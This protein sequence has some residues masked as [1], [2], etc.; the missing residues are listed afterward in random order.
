MKN[1]AVDISQPNEVLKAAPKAAL[2]TD[3][4]SD[5]DIA[6]K[7]AAPSCTELRMQLE[8][9]MLRERVQENCQMRCVHS[10]AMLADC[11]TK[12]MDSTTLRN[13]LAGGHY[14]LFDYST[15]RAGHRQSLKWRKERETSRIVCR[16]SNLNSSST[17]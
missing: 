8:W 16:Q 1:P 3:C 2:V 6:T 10:K 9:L 12:V 4:K 14:A 15:S 7:T 17:S 11:L 13:C 5:F